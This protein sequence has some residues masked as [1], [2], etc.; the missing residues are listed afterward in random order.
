M[1]FLQLIAPKLYPISFPPSSNE[2]QSAQITSPGSGEDLT[3]DEEFAINK[4]VEN[5]NWKAQE[6]EQDSSFVETDDVGV[7]GLPFDLETSV[8]E[9][10]QVV[11]P[12][13]NLADAIQGN[14]MEISSITAQV[15][16]Q[17][18]KC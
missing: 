7:S 9:F 13:Q 10:S 8:R 5:S 4:V 3:S 11:E 18:S 6:S 16:D 12:E 2:D 15:R 1:C 17:N 14:T